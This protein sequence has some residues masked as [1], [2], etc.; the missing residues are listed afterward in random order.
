MT[1]PLWVAN[2][3]LKLQGIKSYVDGT[4]NNHHKEKKQYNGL[5][6]IYYTRNIWVLE[7]PSFW[8]IQLTISMIFKRKHET[9]SAK[10]IVVQV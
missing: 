3:R 2:T 1:T 5:I 6:G 9:K 10:R 4:K 8:L 7:S